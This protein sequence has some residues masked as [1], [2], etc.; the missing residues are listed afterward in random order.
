MQVVR[1]AAFEG[2]LGGPSLDN[3][4]RVLGEHGI[5]AASKKMEVR[6]FGVPPPTLT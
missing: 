5:Q 2:E 3:V 4:L 6:I 1:A